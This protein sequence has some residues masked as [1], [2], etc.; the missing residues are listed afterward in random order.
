MPQLSHSYMNSRNIRIRMFLFLVLF[1]HFLCVF[2]VLL[3]GNCFP[4]RGMIS[5][6]VRGQ[7]GE[8]VYEMGEEN[9][10]E[11]KAGGKAVIFF[12]R[13]GRVEESRF[14]APPLIFPIHPLS[15]A[16]RCRCQRYSASSSRTF[17]AMRDGASARGISS[18]SREER[19]LN[20]M[21]PFSRVLGERTARKG[22]PRRSASLNMEPAFSPRSS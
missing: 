15:L 11:G 1:S 21:Q 3:S 12:S 13:C 4:L 17:S 8:R 20:S 10:W 14:A 9:V 16:A 6:L 22:M 7:A 18:A 5:A 2:F 19:R